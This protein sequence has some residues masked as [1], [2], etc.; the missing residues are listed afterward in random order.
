MNNKKTTILFGFK[1]IYLYF[2]TVISIFCITTVFA[3]NDNENE[4]D[5]FTINDIK[6]KTF[7][8][9][10]INN[11]LAINI[12][13]LNGSIEVNVLEACINIGRTNI[14]P[15]FFNDSLSI[16]HI[17][18]NSDE[19]QN[20]ITDDKTTFLVVFF[21][22]QLFV[23][24]NEITTKIGKEVYSTWSS[25]FYNIEMYDKNKDE[26]II[27]MAPFLNTQ[28]LK[29]SKAFN[30]RNNFLEL[31]LGGA[32]QI[33]LLSSL[34]NP[35]IPSILQHR[36]KYAHRILQLPRCTLI[37][38]ITIDSNNTDITI[39]DVLQQMHDIVNAVEY[40]HE[41]KVAHGDIELSN[42]FIEDNNKIVLSGFERFS[43]FSAEKA[44]VL[45][46]KK[47]NFPAKISYAP[48]F[49]SP[50]GNNSIFMAAS[51]KGDI[52]SL[53]VVLAAILHLYY[54][55]CFD[56]NKLKIG[57]KIDD[58]LCQQQSLDLCF[59][60]ISA[61]VA[62]IIPNIIFKSFRYIFSMLNQRL[63]TLRPKNEN[64][65][66]TIEAIIAIINS[67]HQ[68]SPEARPTATEIKNKL[69]ELMN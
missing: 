68:L 10:Q 37:K 19:F 33:M 63:S 52:W 26:T 27:G 60:V 44:K 59:N 49:L 30:L 28:S 43:M 57:Y 11:G 51:C 62:A 23:D 16:Y 6:A 3:I 21:I 42:L 50:S 53:G 14:I 36:G 65:Q 5:S 1:Y 31:V 66:Q 40:L 48:E 7:L 25:T 56:I 12:L 64:F 2:L 22:K 55:D 8:F 15:M 24:A 20:N 54:E 18:I 58:Y 67:C 61:K 45:G 17:K 69:S 41:N 46:I 39:I 32:R 47:F 13:D 35:N 34:D 9:T 4:H 29:S 38:N